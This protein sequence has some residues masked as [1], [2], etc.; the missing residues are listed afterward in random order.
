MTLYVGNL[1][2]DFVVR[3]L[4]VKGKTIEP[5]KEREVEYYSSQKLI[6]AAKYIQQAELKEWGLSSNYLRVLH[7]RMD[8][9]SSCFRPSLWTWLT[10][11]M[12]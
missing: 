9:V 7:E 10:Q 4:K 12:A 1:L 3:A 8:Y 2:K 11:L 5:E 6:R